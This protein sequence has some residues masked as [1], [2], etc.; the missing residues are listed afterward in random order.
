MLTYTLENTVATITLDD[1]KANALSLPMSQ[2]IAT[3][4][5]RAQTEA[6]VVLLR[7]RPGVL[8]G[9][10][11]LK[12]IRTGTQAD[13]AAMVD[14]GM[15]LLERIY[16][17]PQPT[18]IACTGH[19]VAAGGLLLL[20]ADIRIGLRGPYKLG[21]NETAIGL[22][23]PEFGLTLARACGWSEADCE[24]LLNASPMH[25]IGKIGIPDAILLKPGKFEPYEWEVMKTHAE[26]GG[27]LLEGDNSSLLCMAR[28]IAYTH[29]EKWDGS[30]Y[31]KGLSGD[32]IPQSARITALADVFD[33]L[34]SERPYKKSWT[35]D[36]AVELIE[37]NGGKHFDP[38]LIGVFI[39]ELPAILK[40]CE[41]FNEP[42]A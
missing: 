5:D 10:F 21:L 32:A 16:R 39:Q 27:K 24:L 4:L 37:S 29:H 41:H 17:H 31:P 13:R 19:A 6:R 25:D 9:G 26:L 40:I 18:I 11:D 36:A 33:A 23:L 35:V 2:A 1:G 14:T 22:S 7:G 42:H 30:G 15:A 38:E 28:E 34:T 20:A 8:C 12:V 3:A